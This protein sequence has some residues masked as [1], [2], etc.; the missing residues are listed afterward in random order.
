[1]PSSYAARG[2]GLVEYAL[3]MVLVAVAVIGVMRELG[4]AIS[5]FY[6]EAVDALQILGGSPA[7]AIVG[8][9]ARWQRY[10]WFWWRVRVEV[11]VNQPDTDVTVDITEGSGTVVSP[12]SK[13]CEPDVEC[14][15]LIR[16][17]S[18]HGTV[19]ASGGGGEKTA[20]W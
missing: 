16:W 13:T 3:L 9:S 11:E 15:F 20:D 1:M 8:V 4:P 10:Y 12:A 6:G 14:L 5:E 7:E 19:R 2:Q 18:H 17:P